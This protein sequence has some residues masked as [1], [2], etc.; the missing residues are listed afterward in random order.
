MSGQTSGQWYS[1]AVTLLNAR[2]GDIIPAIGTP[3]GGTFYG[4]MHGVYSPV[5]N[6]GYMIGEGLSPADISYFST[7]ATSSA[8]VAYG[9]SS[10]TVAYAERLAAP[11]RLV[12]VELAAVDSLQLVL[13][14]EKP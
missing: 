1:P 12:G 8:I 10:M 11:L 3:Y 2:T 4:T 13:V 9:D 5:N 6:K 7:D 14:F